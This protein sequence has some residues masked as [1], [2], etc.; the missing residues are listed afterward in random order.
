MNNSVLLRS[1]ICA[2]FFGL[3]LSCVTPRGSNVKGSQDTD[4][5]LAVKKKDP[6]KKAVV[7]GFKLSN[8]QAKDLYK[9]LMQRVDSLSDEDREIRNNLA[10]AKDRKSLDNAVL[11]LLNIQSV[12]HP[13]MNKVPE[14]QESDLSQSGETTNSQAASSERLSLEV[15]AE[16]EDFDF[17]KTLETNAYLK[18]QIAAAELTLI[19][20]S[21]NR[22]GSVS[23]QL[24]DIVKNKV[25]AWVRLGKSQS[26]LTAEDLQGL[27]QLPTSETPEKSGA[28]Q[29][30]GVAIANIR[31]AD[32]IL[33][34]SQNLANQGKYKEAVEYSKLVPQDSPL[35]EVAQEKTV[36]FSNQ[37]VKVLRQQ[38]ARAFQSAMTNFNR[39]SRKSYLVEAKEYLTSAL[40]SFPLSEE[41]GKIQANLDIIDKEL[42]KLEDN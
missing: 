10:V 14:V 25:L 20:A 33:E 41:T 11:Y 30:Q 36:Q 12:I 4:K 29:P 31:N 8:A 24:Y 3:V 21:V 23:N 9:R 27:E 15:F 18:D 39:D 5:K 37:G 28:G 35:F 32:E 16:E 22:N 19:A 13:I 2:L 26:L 34:I 40:D 1:F 42:S 7:K 6:G 17:V 38:A